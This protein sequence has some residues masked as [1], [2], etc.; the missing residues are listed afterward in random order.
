MSMIW[1]DPTLKGRRKQMPTFHN[2]ECYRLRGAPCNCLNRTEY[3]PPSHYTGVDGHDVL[4]YDSDTDRYYDVYD[5]MTRL[6][7]TWYPEKMMH[8]LH[9][10]L[11]KMI[12]RRVSDIL[13]EIQSEGPVRPFTE[14]EPIGA[15]N[16]A[17]RRRDKWSASR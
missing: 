8:H 6:Y 14:G 10:A 12:N 7:H 16:P 9:P 17:H 13:Q 15:C 5:L 3:E 4:M 1:I 2:I 11:E